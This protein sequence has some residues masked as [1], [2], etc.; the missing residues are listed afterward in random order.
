MVKIVTKPRKGG[1]RELI[2]EQKKGKRLNLKDEG[3]FL[4]HKKTEI[5]NNIK[6]II[7][8]SNSPLI[9]ID[10]NLN[11]IATNQYFYN[12]T[13]IQDNIIGKSIKSLFQPKK[14]NSNIISILKKI[15]QKDHHK[16]ILIIEDIKLVNSHHC[17]LE[18]IRLDNIFLKKEDSII[19]FHLKK[20][21]EEVATSNEK[22]DVISFLGHELRSPLTSLKGYN[23]LIRKTFQEK[24]YTD[25][26]LYHYIDKIEGQ[27]DRLSS[28]IEETLDFSRIHLNKMNLN[29][30]FCNF[31][32][33]V[34]DLIEDLEQTT[35][36]HRIILQGKLTEK[37]RIDEKRIRQALTNLITNAIKYSPKSEK[38]I[39]KIKEL[40]NNTIS[41]S[42]QDFGIGI[43]FNQQQKIFEKLYQFNNKKNGLGL[44]LY[45]T[46]YIINKHGGNINVK[47]I[48]NKGS[49]FTF[50][51]PAQPKTS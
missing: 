8:I 46:K 36:K 30:S 48:K 33:L 39:V 26:E 45:I 51:L 5:I 49:I 19:L 11:I 43:P 47:S 40:K 31:N 21:N 10:E 34:L 14:I 28:L 7:K 38:I 44:G 2:T 24:N 29:Y 17:V 3:V 15:K 9:L 23:Q 20:S 18:I 41:V 32:H 42:V 1:D 22:I 4:S 12:T 16:N 13:N 37:V 6:E 25:P 27:I 35:K 50:H